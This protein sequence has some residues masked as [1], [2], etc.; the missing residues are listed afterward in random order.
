MSTANR[1]PTSTSTS[2]STSTPTTTTIPSHPH[3]G[4]GS[5]RPANLKRTDTAAARHAIAHT[6]S[7]KPSVGRRQ[8]WSQEDQKREV[9]MMGIVDDDA[10]HPDGGSGG[11]GGA[12]VAGFSER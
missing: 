11:G 1:P 3:T 2:T 5:D 7:W 12:K 10:D 4:G 9:Q 8:S 6:K